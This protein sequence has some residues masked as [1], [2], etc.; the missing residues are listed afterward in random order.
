LH[1]EQDWLALARAAHR[2]N[3]W[4]TARDGFRRAAAEGRDLE[5]EDLHGWANAAWWLGDL[6]EANQHLQVAHQR[7][8]G[9]GRVEDAALAA[10]EIAVNHFLGGDEPLASGW[11][12]RAVRLLEGVP[13]GP[14]HGYITYIREVEAN[15]RSADMDG[16]VEAARRVQELGRQHADPA[17]VAIGIAGEARIL[18]RHGRAQQGLALLDEAMVSVVAGEL[19]PDWAGNVY[20]NAIDACHELGDLQRMRR[21]ID[22]C[23]TWLASLPAAVL[24]A[25]ICRVH[26]AQVLCVQGDWARAEREATRVCDELQDVYASVVAEA[27]YQVG[28][29]RRLRGD[30]AGAEEAYRCAHV[31]GRDPQPGLALLRMGQGR[32]EEAVAAVR[33]A[34]LAAG[35]TP[36]AQARILPAQVQVALGAG[37]VAQARQACDA[38]ATIA[39]MCG[40]SGLTAAAV[41]AEGAV[42]LAEGRADEA[43][44]A[45]R[46][47][48]RRWREIDAPYE[49]ACVCVVLAEVYRALGDEG[50]ARLEL[51][52]AAAAFERLGAADALERLSVAREPDARPPG[53]LS[54]REVEVLGQVAAG[55]SNRDIARALDISEKTVA[56]HLSNIFT[57]L[58][59][60]SRTE[61]A[62]YAFEHRIARPQG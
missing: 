23:E 38:L 35:D 39:R 12:G 55:R 10:L 49:A 34:L 15:F 36:L 28:E 27:W 51:D 14:T 46:E 2:R 47:G 45:L 33:T 32:L 29:V 21:W 4:T 52:A 25:G 40:S 43:L 7:H 8:V 13:E 11:M 30:L 62:R 53:G 54:V 18:L 50:A 58:D 20:C 56:R 24:F 31:H 9:A 19:P 1:Q 42:R 44:P 26:R 3:D 48:C 61:A 5:V 60:S 22:A 37:D 6:R 41:C 17:L 59:V 16:V 57:K